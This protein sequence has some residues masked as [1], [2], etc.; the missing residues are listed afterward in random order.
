MLRAFPN[1]DSIILFMV[2]LRLKTI[3]YRIK[4][5]GTL[6]GQPSTA[7]GSMSMAH[8]ADCSRRLNLL[9][10]FSFIVHASLQL[11][12]I[13]SLLACPEL[14]LT[15]WFAVSFLEGCKS[16]GF[17][18]GLGLGVVAVA[19]GGGFEVWFNIY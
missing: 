13:Y 10:L 5:K 19:G 17:G 15:K 12:D 16:C 14:T 2:A 3:Y 9:G 6:Q 11:P 7:V 8:S 4:E 1:T 18:L